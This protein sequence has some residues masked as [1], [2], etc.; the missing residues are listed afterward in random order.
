MYVLKVEIDFFKSKTFFKVTKN[1]CKYRR[2]LE[3][4][5][6]AVTIHM[7]GTRARKRN[8]QKL[9]FSIF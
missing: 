5:K 1:V 4:A 2:N 3:K 6:N 9:A 8:V 7:L